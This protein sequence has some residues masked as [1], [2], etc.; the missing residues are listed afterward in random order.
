[1]FL[2]AL[3]ALENNRETCVDRRKMFLNTLK[4]IFISEPARLPSRQSGNLKNDAPPKKIFACG[5]RNSGG[6]CPP[7]PPPA[8]DGARAERAERAPR[9]KRGNFLGM[10]KNKK[11]S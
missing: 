5:A 11:G 8:R 9:A 2:H 4:N 10:G 7:R 1:M 6:V 3:L